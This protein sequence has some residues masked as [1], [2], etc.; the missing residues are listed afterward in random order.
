MKSIRNL[1]GLLTVFAAGCSSPTELA[2]YRI[3]VD[4]DTPSGSVRGSGVISVWKEEVINLSGGG[5]LTKLEGQAIP[6]DLPNGQTLWMTIEHKGLDWAGLS[7][8]A[9]GTLQEDGETVSIDQRAWPV[10]AMFGDE[11]NPASVMEV[12]PSDFGDSYEVSGVYAAETSEPVSHKVDE[13][14]IWIDE[15]DGTFSGEEASAILSSEKSAPKFIYKKFFKK[16][17]E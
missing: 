3:D 9:R 13:R 12:N 1:V 16:E 7:P 10:F 5:V 6:V 11:R 15:I 4:V 17:I 14:L 8:W 2:R